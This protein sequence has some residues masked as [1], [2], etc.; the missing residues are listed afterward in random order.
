MER[1]C[2]TKSFL[3]SALYNYY[4]GQQAEDEKQSGTRL[5]YFSRALDLIKLAQKAVEKEKKKQQLGETVQFAFDV[6][7]L[8]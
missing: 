2:T 1:F 3:Y 6:I 8:W 7:L 5:F 4:L